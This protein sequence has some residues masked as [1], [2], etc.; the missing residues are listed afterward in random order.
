MA[1]CC[2]EA[3]GCSLQCGEGA[4]GSYAMWS[5][6]HYLTMKLAYPGDVTPA[7]PSFRRGG[8]WVVDEVICLF[9]RVSVAIGT[10]WAQCCSSSNI[11]EPPPPP[12]STHPS[13]EC[14]RPLC[15]SFCRSTAPSSTSVAAS[16][17][18]SP[19]H[20]AARRG[21]VNHHSLLRL[22]WRMPSSR[23]LSPCLSLSRS[24]LFRL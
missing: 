20:N 6:S 5:E 4:G 14:D 21:R 1:G 3:L 11:E 18:H 15:E 19:H 13:L 17:C 9:A 10:R 23:S 2:G 24:L 12:S 8:G 16:C 22:N 7:W